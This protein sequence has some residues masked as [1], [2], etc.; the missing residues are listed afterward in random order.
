MELRAGQRILRADF[1]NFHSG[2]IVGRIGGSDRIGIEAGAVSDLACARPAVAEM[3]RDTLVGMARNDPGRSSQGS[4]FV[5]Q[6]DEVGKYPS[7][8]SAPGADLVRQ[9]QPLGSF[10]T[11]ES[12]IIPGKLSQRFRQLLQP[13]VVGEAAVEKRRVGLKRNL[14]GVPRFCLG[15]SSFRWRAPRCRFSGFRGRGGTR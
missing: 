6:L 13:T 1:T 12:S 3:Q 4:P 15:V 10:R 8:F 7:M 14:E 11:D 9:S 5:A 2:P